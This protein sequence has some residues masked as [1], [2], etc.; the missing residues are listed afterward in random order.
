[1]CLSRVC[2]LCIHVQVCTRVC[3]EQGAALPQ[4]LLNAIRQATCITQH[5]IHTYMCLLSF[6][7]CLGVCV[8]TGRGSRWWVSWG[9]SR[10]GQVTQGVCMGWGV[11]TAGC[12]Q[13]APLGVSKGPGRLVPLPAMPFKKQDECRSHSEDICKWA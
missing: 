3:D 13:Q 5:N 10:G 6:L 11:L 4:L 12:Q 8:C 1:M 2:L 7:S 9:R